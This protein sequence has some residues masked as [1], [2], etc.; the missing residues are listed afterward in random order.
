M[1]KNTKKKISAKVEQFAKCVCLAADPA[2]QP[3]NPVPGEAGE[4]AGSGGEAG[5]EGIS[6]CYVNKLCKTGLTGLSKKPG[7]VDI[8]YFPMMK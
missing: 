4:T 1:S 2:G 6:E 5:G 7:K 3:D 8:D